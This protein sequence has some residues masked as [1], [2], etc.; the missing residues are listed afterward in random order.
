MGKGELV[1]PFTQAGSARCL[2][3]GSCDTWVSW[4]GSAEE[5]AGGMGACELASLLMGRGAGTGEPVPPVV[6][7]ELALVA[8]A[9]ESWGTDPT[10]LLPRPRSSAEFAHP[11]I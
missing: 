7:C 11:N 1:P 4:Q 10:Q 6:G 2:S 5:L 8:M 3:P 9:Q